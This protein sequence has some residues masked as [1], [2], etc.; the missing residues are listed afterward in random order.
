MVR[1]FCLKIKE[2][3]FEIYYVFVDEEDQRKME[4]ELV[5]GD[6][7]V[8]GEEKK[9]KGVI[10]KS[11][12]KKKGKKEKDKKDKDNEEFYKKFEFELVGFD[13]IDNVFIFFVFVINFFVEMCECV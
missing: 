8:K 12:F 9:E 7:I 4:E 2:I 11:D 10:G 13:D 6:D 5:E 1:E 3:I